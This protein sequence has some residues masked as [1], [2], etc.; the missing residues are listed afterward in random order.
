MSVFTSASLPLL[1][2]ASSG[3]AEAGSAGEQPARNS[4]ATDESLH[5]GVAVLPAAPEIFG[6]PHAFKNSSI[7]RFFL[8]SDKPL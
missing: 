2:F 8:L 7:N 6:S 1:I 4:L 3:E 5:S